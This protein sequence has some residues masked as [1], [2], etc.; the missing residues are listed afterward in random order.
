MEDTTFDQLPEINQ[1]RLLHEGTIFLSTVTDCF[2]AAKGMTLWNQMTEC[3]GSDFQSAL[4]MRLL[5]GHSNKQVVITAINPGNF[6]NAI[7]LLRQHTAMSLYDAKIIMDRVR[8]G[9]AVTV[10]L[11]DIDTRRTFVKEMLDIGATVR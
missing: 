10:E 5:S 6:I 9:T 4:F 7:K 8:A 2:G 1:E 11:S 3:L